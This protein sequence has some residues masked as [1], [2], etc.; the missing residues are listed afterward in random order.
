MKDLTTIDTR[1][2]KFNSQL[3]TLRLAMMPKEW[4]NR[5][6]VSDYTGCFG[7][8]AIYIISAVIPLVTYRDGTSEE[9]DHVVVRPMKG[10]NDTP[11]YKIMSKIAET[12]FEKGK[13]F[14]MQV[15]PRRENYVSI[16]PYTLHL[17][18]V[19]NE[20]VFDFKRILEE[21]KNDDLEFDRERAIKEYY[22]SGGNRCLAIISQKDWP[23]WNET[24]QIK[25]KYWGEG[26]DAILINRSFQEDVQQFKEYK[27]ILLWDATSVKLPPKELV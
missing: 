16:E 12:F 6:Y 21:I 15:I 10:I 24:V 8:K 27:V 7:E 11:S 17:W 22:D 19:K 13:E 1:N 23:K 3:T 2:I 20:C 5:K 26:M 18:G 9:W 25:E 14:A 4:R